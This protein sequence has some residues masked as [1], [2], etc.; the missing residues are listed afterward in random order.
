MAS[1]NLYELVNNQINQLFSSAES[2]IADL[3]TS[4]RNRFYPDTGQAAYDNQATWEVP[5][6][7]PITLSSLSD[8]PAD[9]PTLDIPPF[10][11]NPED[12]LDQLQKYSYESEFFDNFL[13]PQLIKFIEAESYFI[14]ESVQ[15]AMFQATHDRDIQT[16]NDQLDAVDRVQARRGFPMP[17]SMAM[18]ARNELIARHG[19]TRNDRNGEITSIIAERGHDGVK[20]SVTASIQMEDIRSKFELEFNKLYW[21]ASD[22]LIRKYEA[23]IRAE[24]AK[25]QGELDLIKA[26]TSVSSSMYDGEKAYVGME[27]TRNLEKMQV[28]VKEM[29]ANVDTWS[30]HMKALIDAN[31][32]AIAYYKSAVSSSTGI[33]NDVRSND[34]ALGG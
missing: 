30:V 13:E 25:F 14:E 2:S 29:L 19:D 8:L 3:K 9:M 4:A 18:A 31:A 12:Y 34:E 28:G 17:T 16:L 26:D 1:E 5:R 6:Q 23:D 27:Q 24:V 10:V 21:Q 33:M 22:Y 15:D 7:N 32:E 11:F 20:H